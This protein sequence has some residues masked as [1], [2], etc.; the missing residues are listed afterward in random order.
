[1]KTPDMSSLIAIVKKYRMLLL[2]VGLLILSLSQQKFV[3]PLVYDVIKSD[4]FLV[5][6]KDKGSQAPVSTP[7]SNIA[8]MHCNNYIK[9]KAEPETS[10]SFP[11]KP[12]KAWDMGNY[13][14]IINSEMT[15]TNN[16]GTHNKKYVCRITYNNGDNEEDSLN[17]DNWSIIGVSESDS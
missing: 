6:S 7:F 14:Y 4:L 1:M 10:L 9:S 8:F 3:M 15:V 16:A 11:E 5:E 13:Q 17:I 2:I 12:L